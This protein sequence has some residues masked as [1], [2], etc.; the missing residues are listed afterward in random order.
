MK[1]S[2]LSIFN[3]LSDDEWFH[4]YDSGT[5]SSTNVFFNFDNDNLYYCYVLICNSMKLFLYF[6]F[7]DWLYILIF[8]GISQSKTY[9]ASQ[10]L[11][12]CLK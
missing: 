5:N 7:D 10:F 6:K 11:I 1:T 8:Y 9:R 12:W 4:K 3:F 2:D